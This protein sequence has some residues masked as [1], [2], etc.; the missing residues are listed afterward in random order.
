MQWCGYHVLIVCI[1]CEECVD[2]RR[3]HK[4][5]LHVQCVCLINV[6]SV[7]KGGSRWQQAVR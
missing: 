1:T 6:R 2:V 3:L 7:A 5:R 4:G